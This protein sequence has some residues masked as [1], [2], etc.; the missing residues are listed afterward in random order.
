MKNICFF[1][2]H[3]SKR[4]RVWEAEL[5]KR[6]ARLNDVEKELSDYAG[7]MED[8]IQ[9]ELKKRHKQLEEVNYGYHSSE[10]NFAHELLVLTKLICETG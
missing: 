9:K 7:S 2:Q 4:L 5:E 1:F 8:V 10:T 3:E 6:E